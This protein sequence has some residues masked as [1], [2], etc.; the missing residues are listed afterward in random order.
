M[1]RDDVI[2]IRNATFTWADSDSKHPNALERFALLVEEEVVFERGQVNIIV[3]ATGSGKTAMLLALLGEMHCALPSSD[4]YVSLPRNGG[5]A[6]VPQEPWILSDTI[7][8]TG[9][10]QSFWLN[11]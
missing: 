1:A 6:Y 11:S 9:S 5:V 8:V 10:M 7:K 3:G 4:S 2:G